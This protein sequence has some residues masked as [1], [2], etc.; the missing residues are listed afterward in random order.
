ML[1]PP[2][3]CLV[4]LGIFLLVG[5]CACTVVQGKL[6]PPY[7]KP[8]IQTSR[9]NAVDP[10]SG[11]RV[12]VLPVSFSTTVADSFLTPATL[13]EG[14]RSTG[15]AIAP[16][17]IFTNAALR[18]VFDV[19]NP[20]LDFAI[21]LTSAHYPLI[22]DP[23]GTLWRSVLPSKIEVLKQNTKYTYD[24]GNLSVG[25]YQS[26]SESLE[27]V[28]G[29]LA[30]DVECYT[31]KA[32]CA[33]NSSY[34]RKYELVDS[35]V[36][37][38][39]CTGAP[40]PYL[41][42]HFTFTVD[43]TVKFRGAAERASCEMKANQWT[44]ESA[45]CV[46]NSSTV[47]EGVT[48]RPPYSSPSRVYALCRQGD[49]LTSAESKS[50]PI[51]VVATSFC[52]GN[53]CIGYTPA[54]YRRDRSTCMNYPLGF[55]TSADGNN[56]SQF[57][58]FEKRAAALW[59]HFFN[60]C[61]W[62]DDIT[63]S[64]PTAIQDISFQC[65]VPKSTGWSLSYENFSAHL[66]D[67]IAPLFPIGRPTRVSGQYVSPTD[68]ETILVE[69]EYVSF[70]SFEAGRW[71]LRICATMRCIAPT[72]PVAGDTG[73]YPS[74]MRVNVSAS[75]LGL[76]TSPH[77]PVVIIDVHSAITPITSPFRTLLAPSVV[78]VDKAATPSSQDTVNM[79]LARDPPERVPSPY[80]ASTSGKTTSRVLCQGDY[81]FSTATNN[82]QPL[83]DS[84]C[85]T[86]YRGR[87]SKFDPAAKACAYPVSRLSDPLVFKPLAEPGPPRVYSPEELREILKTVKLP[88]FLRT[89]EASYEE[90]ERQMAQREGRSVRPPP[91][92]AA[93]AEDTGVTAAAAAVEAGRAYDDNSQMPGGRGMTIA[94][95]AT[96]CF[97]WTAAL[98]R[99]VLSKWFAVGPWHDQRPC[100]FVEG[101]AHC[102]HWLRKESAEIHRAQRPRQRGHTSG[103]A[104]TPTTARASVSRS[105]T[106]AKR[107]GGGATPAPSR[108]NENAATFT[109]A[110]PSPSL[111]TAKPPRVA[112]GEP[113]TSAAFKA[114]G[115]TATPQHEG[116]GS[117][118]RRRRARA[119]HGRGAEQEHWQGVPAGVRR[120]A[121][122]WPDARPFVSAAQQPV[123]DVFSF[124]EAPH[125]PFGSESDFAAPGGMPF[126][127]S[128]YMSHGVG[129]SD[130]GAGVGYVPGAFARPRSAFP[131]Q[132][133]SRSPSPYPDSFPPS[134]RRHT[135][136]DTC[137]P[138]PSP[139]Y[140]PYD[141]PLPEFSP[142]PP[143]PP[144]A[145]FDAFAP[146]SSVRQ[147]SRVEVLSSDTDG[148]YGDNSAARGP[149]GANRARR[150][151]SID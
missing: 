138:A 92:R 108:R 101:A 96:T 139:R 53:Q 128:D 85:A 100:V 19:P 132:W 65:D 151:D 22:Q 81:R 11:A 88:Q 134:P 56:T 50:L 49:S 55:Y 93:P 9:D 16:E 25:S 102:W 104:A 29:S 135:F 51:P 149:S 116:Q 10:E 150:L 126:M 36:P 94:C 75:K 107:G 31:S 44:G 118:Q 34:Y 99:D 62:I 20:G 91:R 83:T 7:T 147:S 115:P 145:G 98:L 26:Q 124:P 3:P 30:A 76:S 66:T 32:C 148:A 112:P 141:A 80:A 35:P 129:F 54:N 71:T 110:T 57:S 17:H 59:P 37:P 43:S 41:L 125:A 142:N 109:T 52:T 69:V 117:G 24:V 113:V 114:K 5:G 130:E 38:Y 8:V 77:E 123:N 27:V 136:E 1:P 82:C 84:D 63:M 33:V 67:T 4:A 58:Y 70:S 119:Y 131:R 90:Y 97:L 21:N 23:N 143:Q 45:L 12:S 46:T 120:P 111:S 79:T 140:A 137:P 15:K 133:H 28:A 72:F 42:R 74:V 144:Y 47:L 95:I 61:K 40:I 68:K 6:R 78:Y 14:T 18:L 13:L 64:S 39:V 105:T 106:P 122:P 73:H 127:G 146:V 87:R 121:S 89:M 48:A 86:K 103:T 60:D 2:R